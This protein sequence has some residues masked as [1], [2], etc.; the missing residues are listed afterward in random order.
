MEIQAPKVHTYIHTYINIGTP[1]P[2]N[3]HC[4]GYGLNHM[5]II[6]CPNDYKISFLKVLESSLHCITQ[7]VTQLSAD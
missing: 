5:R 6:E 3:N 1:G 4:L 2:A 7:L